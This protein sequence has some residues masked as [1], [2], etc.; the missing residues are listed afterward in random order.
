MTV[1][2]HILADDDDRLDR[3]IVRAMPEL[4]RSQ[5]RRLIEADDFLSG[6]FL[7]G[8][9]PSAEP[10]TDQLPSALAIVDFPS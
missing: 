6:Q 3:A 10:R 4:S 8:R 1:T 5:I 2:R 9:L 7:Q